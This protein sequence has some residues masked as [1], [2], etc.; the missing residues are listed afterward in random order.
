VLKRVGAIRNARNLDHANPRVVTMDELL[1][2]SVTQAIS[3]GR[4]PLEPEADSIVFPVPHSQ[5]D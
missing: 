3:I 1:G 4:R 2:C 5:A